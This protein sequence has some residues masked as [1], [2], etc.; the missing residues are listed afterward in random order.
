MNKKYLFFIYGLWVIGIIL[1]FIQFRISIEK[2]FIMWYWF[3]L[4]F[5][6]YLPQ[7]GFFMESN[8]KNNPVENFNKNKNTEIKQKTPNGGIKP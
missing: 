7:L 3:I 1:F 2:W 8:Y 5:L 6:T 4:L